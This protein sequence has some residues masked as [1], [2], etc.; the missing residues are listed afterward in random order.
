MTTISK[1]IFN[2]NEGKGLNMEKSPLGWGILN[3]LVVPIKLHPNFNSEM[4][5]E[6]LYGMVVKVLKDI[7]D[8]WYYIETH[9]DYS[10]YVH[11]SNMFMCDEKALHWKNSAKNVITHSIVD[12]MAEATY[13]SYIVDVLTRG[14]IVIST[15]EEKDGW[16][17]IELLDEKKGWV[18]SSFLGQLKKEANKSNEDD[19]RQSLVNTALSYIGTQYRWGGRSPIGIDCSGLCSISYLLNGVVI[20][21][22]AK[23]KSEYMREISIDEIKPGDL[24][25]FPGHVA[26]YIGDAKYVHSSSSINGVAINSLNPAHHDYREDLAKEIT[27]VGTIF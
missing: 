13:K 25:F 6:G 5:D 14:A 11:S 7:G 17:K 18:R 27:G 10:G 22:D 20:Y 9:Y 12:V 21:R 2:N 26:M 23:L 15:G 16:T 1:E 24:I 3:K 4:A 19:L 8:G